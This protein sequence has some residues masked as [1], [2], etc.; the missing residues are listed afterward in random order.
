MNF[1][2]FHGLQIH[3][4][5]TSIENVRGIIL[6]SVCN[7][8]RHFGNVDDFGDDL[9]D[10]WND[11]KV[12]YIKNNLSHFHLGWYLLSRR[13]DAVQTFDWVVGVESN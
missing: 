12:Q 8:G 9:Y 7:D 11:L 13:K 4:T 1:S 5:S 6:G 2:F 3:Q 10:A